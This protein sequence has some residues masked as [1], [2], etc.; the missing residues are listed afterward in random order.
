MK[1]DGH[2]WIIGG[3]LYFYRPL[4]LDA[5]NMFENVGSKSYGQLIGSISKEKPIACPDAMWV[6]GK[7]FS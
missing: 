5:S 7:H 4:G 6:E 1:Y 3:V 2:N